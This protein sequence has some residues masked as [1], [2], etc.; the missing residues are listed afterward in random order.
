MSDRREVLDRRKV[1]A[2]AGT[3]GALAVGAALVPLAGREPAAAAVESQ[4]KP[5]QEGGYRATAH[6]LQYY[7]TARV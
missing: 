2:G 1:L 6:V 7:Q 5:G 3:V 4:P